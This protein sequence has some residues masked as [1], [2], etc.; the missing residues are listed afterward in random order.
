MYE[1]VANSQGGAGELITPIQFQQ[2][3][4]LPMVTPTAADPWATAGTDPYSAAG[5]GTTDFYSQWAN[6]YGQWPQSNFKFVEI[7]QKQVRCFS[8]IF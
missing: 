5:A 1:K 4:N 8:S 2:K 6:A 7:N 3:Y